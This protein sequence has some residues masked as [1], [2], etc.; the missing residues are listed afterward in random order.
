MYD[1]IIIGGGPGG[2][3]SALYLGRFRRHVLLI[4][5]GRPRARWIPRIRNLAGCAQGISGPQ[6]LFQLKKQVRQYPVDFLRGE[7]QVH[8]TKR[9]FCVVVGPYRIKARNVILAT[10]FEDKQ[11]HVPNISN[12]RRLQLLGYCPICDGYDHMRHKVAMLVTNGHCLTKLK[13]VSRL[14]PNL[15]VIPTKDFMFSPAVEKL[16]TERRIRL[17]KAKLKSFEYSSEDMKLNIF[18]VGKNRPLKVDFAYVLLGINF[19]KTATKHLKG[20]KRVKGGFIKTTSHQ[21]TSIPGLYAVGDCVNA[22]AQV[23][24]AIGQAALAATRIHLNLLLADQES[25]SS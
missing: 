2:L 6:L 24:V 7:A 10:G 21:E 18:F 15:V 23:S 20:L 3:V 8:R 13:F 14:C 9:G 25:V 22:L 1:C 11:P 16:A 17:L 12:L 5:A 19:N 4:D